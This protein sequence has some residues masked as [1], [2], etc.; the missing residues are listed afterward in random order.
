[1]GGS[2]AS[3][4]GGGIQ[5]NFIPK[6]GGNT[7]RGS[8]RYFNVNQKFEANNISNAQRDLGAAGGNP[9]QDIKD[10]GFEMGG[11]ILK[12]RFGYWG[13]A[14]KNDIDVGVVNFYDA[15]LG[16]TCDTL[17]KNPDLA[18]SKNASG[19]YAYEI[20]SLWDCYKTDN[21]QLN[22]YNGKLQFQENVGNKTT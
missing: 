18:N 17:A 3:Q 19:S 8:A 13:T 20:K 4:Q 10:D 22:N 9:I 5:I 15:S 21:T 1:K 2:D 7:V 11:P 6:S 12:N 16:G 14:S